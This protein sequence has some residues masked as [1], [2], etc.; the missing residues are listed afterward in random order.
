[1]TY[2]VLG[3]EELRKQPEMMEPAVHAHPPQPHRSGYNFRVST[4]FMQEG[5]R[6]KGALP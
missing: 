4:R 2:I 6:F 5:C 1:M 3:I